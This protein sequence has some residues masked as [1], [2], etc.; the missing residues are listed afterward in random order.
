MKKFCGGT[1]WGSAA[2][3]NRGDFWTPHVECYQYS[4]HTCDMAKCSSKHTTWCDVEILIFS[5]W[6][7]A[8]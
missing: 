1:C 2:K 6:A 8:S 5:P 7:I 4:P 3:R